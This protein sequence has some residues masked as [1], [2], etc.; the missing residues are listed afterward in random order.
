[1]ANLSAM[2]DEPVVRLA[3]FFFGDERAHLLF[4]FEHIFGIR[5]AQAIAHPKHMCIHRE[6]RN[7]KC[8]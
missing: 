6:S 4:G 2:I 3:P 1:M 7:A 8:V 5:Q